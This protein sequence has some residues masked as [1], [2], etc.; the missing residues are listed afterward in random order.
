[1][2]FENSLRGAT[3]MHGELLKLGIRVAQLVRRVARTAAV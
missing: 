1:M 2:S 3:K